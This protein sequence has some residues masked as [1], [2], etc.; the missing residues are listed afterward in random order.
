M[1]NQV[2]LLSN[3]IIFELKYLVAKEDMAHKTTSFKRSETVLN[4]LCG[5][6]E[7]IG[8]EALFEIHIDQ[9]ML[10]RGLRNKK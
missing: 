4:I 8:F 5:S 3:I 1:V 10:N 6:Y 2:T 7:I 9:V